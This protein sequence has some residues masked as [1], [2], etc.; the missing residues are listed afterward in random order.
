MSFGYLRSRM[1]PS[2][3]SLQA[4]LS[5][6]HDAAFLLAAVDA[7]ARALAAAHRGQ[8]S[9]GSIKHKLAQYRSTLRKLAEFVSALEQKGQARGK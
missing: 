8:Q 6:S 3:E 4:D 2:D 5:L 1:G 7:A 9:E